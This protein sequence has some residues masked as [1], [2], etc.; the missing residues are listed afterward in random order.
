M[1]GNAGHEFGSSERRAFPIAD[2]CRR[3]SI[4]RTTAYREIAAGR[5]RAVKVG[6]RTLITEEAAKDWLAGLPG[7]QPRA[8]RLGL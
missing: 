3:Y 2:F 1:P 7:M 4:G 8:G 6:R 5:L